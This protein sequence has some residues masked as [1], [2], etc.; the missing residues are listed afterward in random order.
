MLAARHCLLSPQGG[1]WRGGRSSQ[2][3]D[4]QQTVVV[5][6]VRVKLVQVT[7][8]LPQQTALAKV[9]IENTPSRQPLILDTSKS[10]RKETGLQL[11]STVVVPDEDSQTIVAITNNG[12]YTVKLDADTER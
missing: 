1:S 8:F 9:Q 6:M 10:F 12:G 2:K 5:P 7:H 11:D 4:C 3:T